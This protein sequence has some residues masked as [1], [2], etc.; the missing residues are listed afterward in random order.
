MG[1]SNSS[2]Q[3]KKNDLEYR[4]QDA[5]ARNAASAVDA[6]RD[7]RLGLER[8]LKTLQGAETAAREDEGL[9]Q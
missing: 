1:G 9:L 2:R 3:V 6:A 4:K 7:R 5:K 8:D